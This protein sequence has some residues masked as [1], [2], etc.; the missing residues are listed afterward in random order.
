METKPPGTVKETPE[1]CGVGD[2]VLATGSNIEVQWLKTDKQDS[3][4]IKIDYPDQPDRHDKFRRASEYGGL[5][6]VW[7]RV[8]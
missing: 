3:N 6:D 4:E 8:E 2:W 1:E 5:G 7:V